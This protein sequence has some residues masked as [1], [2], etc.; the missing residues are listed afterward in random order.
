MRGRNFLKRKLSS[1]HSIFKELYKM[2]YIFYKKSALDQ[3]F[4]SQAYL[5]YVM[6]SSSAICHSSKTFLRKVFWRYLFFKKGNKNS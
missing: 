2:I 1:P 6:L 5:F 3:K 4:I